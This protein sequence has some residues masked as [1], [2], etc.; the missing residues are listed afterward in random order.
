M[1][2]CLFTV[3]FPVIVR[4]PELKLQLHSPSVIVKA[5]FVVSAF[6][7]HGLI[8]TANAVNSDMMTAFLI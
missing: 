4:S 7:V 1:G 2:Q 3:Q 5:P 6:A 8:I